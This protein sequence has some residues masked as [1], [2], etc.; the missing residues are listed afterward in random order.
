MSPC[1]FAES[2]CH[3][4]KQII[5]SRSGWADAC[6]SYLLARH[7]LFSDGGD[8][9]ERTSSWTP[10]P[11]RLG[12]HC[13]PVAAVTLLACVCG[14]HLLPQHLLE[15]LDISWVNHGDNCCC[16][17]ASSC[18]SCC[19][20]TTLPVRFGLWA[21]EIWILFYIKPE[22]GVI[23]PGTLQLSQSLS[24]I[25]HLT[26]STHTL[27]PHNTVYKWSIMC[28]PPSEWGLFLVKQAVCGHSSIICLS[29][30]TWP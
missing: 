14:A 4:I 19:I 7:W 10:G 1:Y 24:H 5:I 17:S 16:C 11:F 29:T 21:V 3:G 15:S 2:A 6:C 22:I 30:V 26:A 25:L 20:L 28:S 8:M 27:P 12:W 18:C 13:A 9:E 23:I